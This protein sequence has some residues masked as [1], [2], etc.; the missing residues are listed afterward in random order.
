MF[1]GKNLQKYF[2][3]VFKIHKNEPKFILLWHYFNNQL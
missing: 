2:R 3:L 1:A